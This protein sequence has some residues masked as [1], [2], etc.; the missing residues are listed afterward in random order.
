MAI[1]RDEAYAALSEIDRTT[2]CSQT[3]RAYR[4]AGPIMMLWGAIWVVGYGSMGI[5]PGGDWGWVW[6]PMDILG[7]LAT[8]V[9]VRRLR[10]G[11]EGRAASLAALAKGLVATVA[12]M[13]VITGI[14]MMA[15][16]TTSAAYMAVPALLVGLTYILIGL[17]RMT[18]FIFVGAAVIIA[19]IVGYVWVEQAF[20]L[21]LAAVGGLG[22]VL[23]G[24]WVWRG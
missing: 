3:L 19:T 18:R 12:I 16:P 15:K 10:G 4:G 17:T 23:G 2:G 22:L 8:M 5:L 1:S 14:F 6:L 20:A 13:A 11:G 21:W 9:M 24:L 7:L